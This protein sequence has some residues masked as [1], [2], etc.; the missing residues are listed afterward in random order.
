LRAQLRIQAEGLTGHLDEFW[1]DVAHSKWFGGDAEGWERAPYWL[2][3]LIPLAWLLEDAT[4]K[5]KAT[6][7]IE[8]ILAGQREDGWYGTYVP[9][10]Q[11]ATKQYDIWAFFLMNK[12]L[13]H[14]HELTGD[15][16]ALQAVLRCLKAMDQH[17]R[18][19]PLFNW[20]KFRWFEDLIAVYY[21]YR[22]TGEVWLLDLARL[23]HEQ[24]FDYP[25]FYRQED[26]TVPTPRRGLWKW[27]KHVVNTA[28]AVKSGALWW[29]LSGAPQD[30]HFPA[31]MIALLDRYHGQ[32]N[33]MFSGDECLAGK[34]PLQGT[35]L[36]AV[37]EMMYSLEQL[38]S[39]LGEAA[40]ADRLERIAFNAL[41][42]TFSPDMWAHQYDQQVNQVQCTINEEHLWTTNGPE[43]NIYGLEPNFGCCTANMHQGW[44]KLAAHL[45]MRTPDQGLAAVAYAP[46]AVVAQVKGKPVTVTLETDYPF[47]EQLSFVI[48]SKEPVR[49]PL[50]LRI[51]A[52]AE[53]A[54]VDVPGLV[55]SP[56]RPGSFAKIERE[57][58]G[59]TRLTLELPM[60]PRVEQ[61]YNDAVAIVRGPLVFSLLI[62]EEWQQVN[63]D[64]PYRQPPH[65]D[66]EV[67]PTTP[68]NYALRVDA[69]NPEHSLSFEERPVGSPPFSPQGA[70]IVAKAKGRRLPN[71]KLQHG[72][73][74]ETP[75]SPVHSEQP[76]EDVTLIPYGC[77]NIRITEFPQ[78]VE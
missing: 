78:L 33:G 26:V 71:W 63:Q 72:W 24:G 15:D 29:Q 5:E 20:G 45:W 67:R 77:S 22:H 60:R 17:L 31:E 57:W 58:R 59:S 41:P 73:A 53:G 42:A 16:R 2:D 8:Q 21:A 11:S 68:W 32:V 69:A 37:V 76:L 52:W 56:L 12:V 13:V 7:R 30:R 39:I 18:H 38:V 66:W 28:M 47:R 6:A 62:G 27:T 25:S 34:N 65:A 1:P 4:L 23:H 51:P 54:K 19:Y 14:Y 35:E 40:L 70:G 3:G 43:S 36:C 64:K 50:W 55:S 48:D 49:F 10:D 46:S 74:G 44:P 75:P 9:P 61:R